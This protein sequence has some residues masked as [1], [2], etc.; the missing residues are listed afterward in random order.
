MKK[1]RKFKI[2]LIWFIEMHLVSINFTNT[3]ETSRFISKKMLHVTKFKQFRNI[4]HLIKF[5][6]TYI[7]INKNGYFFIK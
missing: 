2:F 5:Q 3:F 4:I 1:L 7:Y 6:Y